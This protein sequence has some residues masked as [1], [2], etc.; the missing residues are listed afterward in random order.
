VLN[1]QVARELLERSGAQVAIAAGGLAGVAQAL[2][3][4]PPFDAILMDLQMPDI[5]G[6]EATRRIH[7]QTRLR[8]TPIIAMTAN[9][10]QSDKADCKAAGMCGHVVK[11]I[12]LEQLIAVILLHVDEQKSTEDLDAKL[13]TTRGAKTTIVVVDSDTAIGRLGGSREFYQT[14]V[15]VFLQDA[16]AQST[17]LVQCVAQ[18][19]YATALR[20]AHT[21]K[22]LAAT[23]GANPLAAAAADTEIMLMRLTGA[24]AEGATLDMV[25]AAL[26]QLETQLALALEI[27]SANV[28]VA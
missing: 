1:Q 3:A 18:A 13:G 27:L 4:R 23:V 11:P 26:A 25:K 8:S 9:A 19:D 10:M 17:E 28:L 24:N 20:H 2:A 22:G 21:L 14:I 12:D 15:K 7:S 16:V 6:F 5:D